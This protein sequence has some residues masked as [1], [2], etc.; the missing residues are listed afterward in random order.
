MQIQKTI[1]NDCFIIQPNIFEDDR[2]YFFE[3]FNENTFQQLTGL[4]VHFVQ[5][6]EAKS[7]RGIVRGLH[8]QIGEDAQA[9][10]VRVAKGKVLDVVVDLRKESSTYLQ[11]LTIELS[12]E[13]RTQL[14]VPRGF[15]HGY[16]VL[17]DDTVFMYKCDN[18]YNPKAEGGV[19][20]DD[21]FFAIDWQLDTAEMMLSVKDKMLPFIIQ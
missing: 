13:N 8:F 9:K 21:A 3:S 1:L 11:H 20:Y 4:K 10:L 7:S 2:G 14:F 6:N 12:G 16:S 5:D 17:E 18:F 15:A 19:R